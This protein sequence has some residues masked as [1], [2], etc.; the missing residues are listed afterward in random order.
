MLETR[1][2]VTA[3]ASAPPAGAARA[4]GDPGGRTTRAAAPRPAGTPA[5]RAATAR[6]PHHLRRADALHGRS[7]SSRWSGRRSPRP[8]TTALAQTPPPS[9][10]AG[11][12]S[13]TTSAAWK[14]PTWARPCSTRSIVA[15]ADRA[16]ARSC[17]PR[18]P[19]FAFAK[20]RFRAKNIAAAAG[21]RHHD[22]AAATGRRTAVHDDRRSWSWAN[23]LQAVILPTMVSAFGVFFMRQYLVKALPTELIE[24]A[25]WTART[26][27]ASSGTSS[28]RSPGRRWRC[29]G[30]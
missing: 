15:G 27:C 25:G 22:G 24:A 3:A 18:S 7:P 14:T 29:W 28:S 2:A 10:S 19:G 9:G 23:Q 26:A 16:V 11:T 30:C 1:T 17:S 21:D 8:A 13:R 4:G 5:R 12:S 20:L 6:R